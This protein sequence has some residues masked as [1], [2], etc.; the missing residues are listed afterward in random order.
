MLFSRTFYSIMFLHSFLIILSFRFNL[1]TDSLSHKLKARGPCKGILFFVTRVSILT[2][3]IY[4][5]TL[6]S[7]QTSL[8]ILKHIYF[9][10]YKL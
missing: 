6:F 5:K 3:D 4:G 10:K 9:R 8:V 7:D 1:E 2:W